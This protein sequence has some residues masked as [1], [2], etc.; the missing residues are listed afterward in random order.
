[1][2]VKVFAPAKVNLTL[3]VTGQ[4]DDGF[5]LLDSLVVFAD[6]GD[7][8][9]VYRSKE[10]TL[11]VAGPE[12]AEVPTNDS[13]SVMHAARLM[14]AEGIALRLEKYLPT[15]AGVGGGT[16]DAA[17]TIRAIA[18][19]CGL[20]LPDGVLGLGADVPVC[21]RGRATRMSGVGEVLA[22]VR[23]LPD[24]WA[25]LVNPR[26]AVATPD[27]FNRLKQKENPAMPV[28]L[29]RFQSAQAL[30]G[31]LS[32]QRNDLQTP[33]I[34]VQPMIAT[35][36]D[37]LAQTQGQLLSRMSGSGATCFALYEN[38][39][40]ARNAAE[41]LYHDHPGWWVRDTKLS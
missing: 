7:M 8:V 6:I 9:S 28:E 11:E 12:A 16:A 26:A 4:R 37:V 14:Q 23:G 19:L 10:I 24:I 40:S 13:N 1:M 34:E 29:P 2:P 36:L 17:A 20:G 5:H 25:V 21:M 15:A 27:V 18:Q 35:V 32:E 39:E 38:G 22:D 33:A 31:W 3:H 41:A 30:A